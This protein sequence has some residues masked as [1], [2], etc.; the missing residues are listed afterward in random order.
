MKVTKFLIGAFALIFSL[1]VQAQTQLIG[2]DQTPAQIQDYVRQHFPQQQIIKLE[3]EVDLSG[4][5]YE[6]KLDNRVKLEF[7]G[8]FGI[9][10]IESKMAL[11]ESVIPEAVRT[12]VGANYPNS[13]IV[14]WKKKRNGQKIELSND[15]EL[16][17][18]SNGQF[19][20]ADR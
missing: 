5:E 18:D 10:E 9:K 15:I 11:P 12:Y 20:R 7:D 8:Q 13:L 2:L 14:E 6:V 4:V 16:Y 3:K 1:S 19:L 17:F